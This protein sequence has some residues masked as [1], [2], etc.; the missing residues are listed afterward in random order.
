M[1]DYSDKLSV[2]E[3]SLAMFINGKMNAQRLGEKL[4]AV[5]SAIPFFG[6]KRNYHIAVVNTGMVKEPFFGACVYPKIDEA[7]KISELT[8]VKSVPFADIKKAWQNIQDWEIELDSQLFNR[9]EINITPK[10]VIAIMLHEIGHVVYSDQ[11]VERFYRAYKATRAKMKSGEFETIKLA[12][13]IF[14]IPLSI[15][16]QLRSWKRGKAGI[17]EEIYADNMVKDAGYGDDYVSAMSKIIAGFGSY[18]ANDISM[19]SDEKVKER[20]RWANMNIVDFVRRKERLASDLYMEGARTP[21]QYLKNMYSSVLRT[22]G[23]NLRENYTGDAVECTIE[24][25]ND[26]ACMETYS[27]NIDTKEF[28]AFDAAV[29]ST[30]HLARFT[31]GTPAFESISFSKKK[32]GL[33]SWIEIDRISI[34]VDKISNQ[35]DRQFVLDMIYDKMNDIT[36]FME[37]VCQTDE[38]RNKYEAEAQRM[39]DALNTQRERV[40]AKRNFNKR[41]RVFVPS[42]EGYEG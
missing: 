1:P 25:L 18:M 42:P 15:S 13:A 34:E 38:G 40:L 11:S 6:V 33:P 29:E 19:M 22:L 36:Q 28:A 35:S 39:L 31:L 20:V 32:K 12:Y 41:Y 37:Y 9:N 16:C 30:L 21:S 14:S 7:N 26:P 3:D 24:I 17:N 5:F 10:E 23:V 8:V 2:A 27:V 4:S